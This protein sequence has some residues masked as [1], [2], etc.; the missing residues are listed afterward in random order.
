MRSVNQMNEF[1]KAVEGGDLDALLDL[2]TEDVVFRSPIVF[3]Q[4]EGREA[5]GTLLRAVIRVFEDFRYD[6]EIGEPG[7]EN[8]ALVFRARVGDRE[9]EGCDFLHF[10]DQGVIDEFFVM[11]RPLSGAHALAG[12]MQQ[13][14]AA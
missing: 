14:L 9:V 1:R 10:N 3:K 7:A 12:A 5:V 2:M 6:R 4:Y 8:N 13:E 11:V